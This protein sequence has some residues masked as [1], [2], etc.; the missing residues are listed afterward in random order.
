MIAAGFLLLVFGLD[1]AVKWPFQRKAIVT[2][3]MFIVAAGLVL[4]QGY[5]TWREVT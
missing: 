2:D 1:L 3:I 5:E 4:W